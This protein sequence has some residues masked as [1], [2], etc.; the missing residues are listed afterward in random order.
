[1]KQRIVTATDLA[2]CPIRSLSPDHYRPDGTCQCVPRRCLR[3]G[4]DMSSEVGVTAFVRRGHR[5]KPAADMILCT[6]CGGN[7][8]NTLTD[9]EYR[10]LPG[11]G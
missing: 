10:A 11:R 2:R 6:E 3:C 9:A 1:M 8:N 7:G 5:L 4:K